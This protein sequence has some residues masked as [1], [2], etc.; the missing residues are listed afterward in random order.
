[1]EKEFLTSQGRFDLEVTACYRTPIYL[2]DRSSGHEE[3]SAIFVLIPLEVEDKDG[4][5]PDRRRWLGS[6]CQTIDVLFRPFL[7]FPT[8]PVI[9]TFSA[10]A[11]IG[12]EIEG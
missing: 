6:A 1:M 4:F 8:G 10:P 9:S 12:A 11:Q 2:H 7:S 3:E 5:L